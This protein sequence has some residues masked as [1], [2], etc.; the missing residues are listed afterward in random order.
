MTKEDYIRMNRGINDS[1]DLPREYLESIYDEIASS[2]IK[3]KTSL[4]EGRQPIN[5]L[6]MVGGEFVKDYHQYTVQFQQRVVIGATM[7]T[8]MSTGD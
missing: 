5:R 4:G 6:S 8:G 3:L 1:K 7:T 2:E